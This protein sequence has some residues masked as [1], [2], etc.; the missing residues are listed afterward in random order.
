MN[1]T[2]C[3]A[4]EMVIDVELIDFFNCDDI[5]VQCSAVQFISFAVFIRFLVPISI[6]ILKYGVGVLWIF[7]NKGCNHP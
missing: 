4:V 6:Q 1:E 2:S 5:A 3:L 7:T